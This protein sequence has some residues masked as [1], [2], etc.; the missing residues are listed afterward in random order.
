MIEGINAVTYG[1][2]IP[3]SA[4][5]ETVENL[6]VGCHMQ[7]VNLGDPAFLK[8]GGHTF[9]MS[10]NVV[11]NGITNSV[12]KTD[13]CAGCHGP[14]TTFDLPRQDYNGDGVIEGVQT[15]VQHML[16]KLSTLLPNAQGV[17]DGLVKT[18]LSVKTNW[19]QQQL[20]AAYN[21]QFVNNDGSKGVH[22]APFATGLLKASIGD[23]TGDANS[24]GLPDTWQIQYFGSANNPLAAPGAD[25]AGDGVPNWVKYTLGLDPTVPGLSIT[26]GLSVGVVWVNGKNVVNPPMESGLTNTVA[27]YMAAEVSFDTEVGKT[28]QIQGISSLSG[29]WQNIGD[30]IV[31]TGSPMSYVTPTRQNAQM[32]FR[33]EHNP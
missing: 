16:D 32:F 13:A 11:T 1:Q 10:Y 18:S 24:D 19:T 17:V 5:R 27:I 15:E 6:C 22:N 26:N 7:T 14:I 8:A 4:H 21:W 25:P 31:G 20:Q 23:L 29:G 2:N 3:S 12:A 33:V 30:P 28:Y 9:E